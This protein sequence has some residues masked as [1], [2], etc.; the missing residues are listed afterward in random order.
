M[1]RMVV[2]ALPGVMSFELGMA[3]RLF[4]AAQQDGEP[5]YQVQTC[6]PDGEPVPTDA[7]FKVTVDHDARLLATADTVVMPPAHG[8]AVWATSTELD[9]AVLAALGQIRPGTRLLGICTGAFFLAAAGLL[10]DRKATTHW[11]DT[12]KLQRNFPDL[13]VLPDVLYIDDGEVMTSAG[14]AA[15]IDLCLHVI[16]KD[17]GS[18]V[19][20]QVSRACVIPPWREG[21]QSQFIEHPVP[22]PRG[23]S[24]AATREWALQELST[25]LALASLAEHARLSRRTFSRRFKAETGL[26]VGTWLLQQ[27]LNLARELLETSQLGIDSIAD[28]AGLGSSSSLRK[29]FKTALGVPPSH[30]RQ[31]FQG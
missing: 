9:P 16:R 23:S 19:A 8:A 27:R 26:S 14:A 20:N 22:Q 12:E 2:L 18:Q 24:T 29:H 6:S 5:L 21:G 31:T 11:R 28:R 1:H 15:G 7:D 4:G 30:Y 13:T 17:H 10:K 25:P 3:A